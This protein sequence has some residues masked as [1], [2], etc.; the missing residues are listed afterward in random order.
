MG[1]EVNILLRLMDD[2]ESISIIGTVVWVTPKGA[3][4]N[5]IAG[6]GV[7]FGEEDTAVR[8]R[9]EN[10]LAGFLDSAHPTHTM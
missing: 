7:Q 9:I 5:R 3:Q 1:D 8:S 10:H 6:V 2:P 4:G